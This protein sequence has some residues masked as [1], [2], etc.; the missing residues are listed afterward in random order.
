MKILYATSEAVPFCK[1]GGLADVAGSLPS[2][3]A[4]EGAEVAVVLPLYR[5]VRERFGSQ[6]TF[7][8]YDYVNLGWRHVYCGLF[9]LEKDGVTWYFLDNEQYF[10]R[11]DL[12]GYMDDGERFG[13]FSRAV[14]RMLD[15]LKFWP[16]VINCNDWQ[17][18][19]VPIYLKDDGVR[20]ER[21][22]S[23]RTTLTVH[24]IEYQGRY[25]PYVLGDLFGL[26]AGWVE[27]GTLLMDG[28]LNLLKG[29]ILCAD[30]VNAVSPTYANELK[31]AYFAHRMESVMR[32]CEYKLYGV[33]NGIDM[34]RYDPAKDP[35]IAANFSAEDMA[36]KDADK[37]HLQRLMGLREEPHAPVVA[38]VSRLVSHKGLDL[39]CEV[40]H[41]MMKLPMQLVVLGKGDKKYEEFFHWAAQQYPGRMAVRLDY[42]E[43][44]SMAIYA[45]ADLFLMPS[46]SEPCGLSQM[47]A[48]RYGTVPIVRET[49]GLK[50]TVH[51]Y[52]AWRDAGNGF[53]FANYAS[54]DMLHVIREAVYLYKDYPDA[55]SRLRKR[56]MACDFSWARSAGE[57][58]RI[59]AGVTG[60]VWPAP[61]AAPAE[62]TPAA[63]AASET[64]AEASVSA[65]EAPAAAETAA[66][67]AR[68]AEAPAPEPETVPAE[69]AVKKA[70]E[71]APA[72][73]AEPK[74]RGRKPGST[75]TAKKAAGETK[76]KGTAPKKK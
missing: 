11:P 17:T 16:D 15:H 13:F 69:E 30:A 10:D 54:N 52:E 41:D 47:I 22:R 7:L 64:P 44:L 28:D 63:E 49:G 37:A 45:G 21:F 26:D 66:E 9:S 4:A 70:A 62:E 20:E 34:D 74:K 71:E 59:Y 67:E 18:A 5:R 42:N 57:Y 35:S 6:L 46:K 75:N 65:E 27:D 19:L 2:A 51:A 56:A 3:L 39:I 12:Y 8:C 48:M 36:G 55:F 31:M 24:N 58:L 76:K 14:V 72:V 53:T 38:I 32:Q 50:D 43:E 73:K 33:L 60:Q 68:P 40:L 23:I 25:N 1:T 29:A 61:E